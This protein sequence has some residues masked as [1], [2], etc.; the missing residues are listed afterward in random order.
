VATF[1]AHGADAESLFRAA[2]AAMYAVKRATKNAVAVAPPA[3]GTA[4]PAR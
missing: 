1:P 4:L 3:Q 2:D